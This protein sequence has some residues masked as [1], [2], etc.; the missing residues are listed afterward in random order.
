MN[1]PEAKPRRDIVTGCAHITNWKFKDGTIRRVCSYCDTDQPKDIPEEQL[2]YCYH[3]GE[4]F[5]HLDDD[6]PIK[7]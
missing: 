5:D 3:C 6:P 4:T 1:N 2:H 7:A